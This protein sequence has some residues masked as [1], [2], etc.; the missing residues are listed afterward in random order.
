MATLTQA[1]NAIFS[2]WSI[3]AIIFLVIYLTGGF[4]IIANNPALILITIL[5]L[6]VINFI[7]K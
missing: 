5:V 3:V 2:K 1:T 7:G 4:E 6:V